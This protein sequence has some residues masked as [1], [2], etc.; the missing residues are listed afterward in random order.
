M[1]IFYDIKKKIEVR[2]NDK[3]RS[4]YTNLVRKQCRRCGKNLRVNSLSN[5]NGNT[6]IKNNVSVNGMHVIGGG[7]TYCWKISPLRQ[8]MPDYNAKSQLRQGKCDS[9]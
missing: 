8:G 5:V 4:Y 3:K 7:G 1:K 2:K 6:I 9:L